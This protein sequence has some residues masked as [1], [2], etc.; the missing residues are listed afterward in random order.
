MTAPVHRC[1]DCRK[2]PTDQQPPKPRP[3]VDGCGPRSERCASHHRA[4]RAAA[5]ERISAAGARKRSGLDDTTLAQLWELQGGRCPCG[6]RPSRRRP[7]ADHDHALAR[8]HDHP[9]DRACEACMRGLLCRRCNREVIGRLDA[10]ALRRLA[11][12]LEDPPMAQLLRRRAAEVA[13]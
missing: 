10:A 13:A 5:R 3:I 8:L 11:D 2:L 1:V 4:K 7:D 9:E 6:N 12:Y